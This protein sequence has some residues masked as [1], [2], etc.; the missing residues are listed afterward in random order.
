MKGIF[1][2]DEAIGSLA[3]ARQLHQDYSGKSRSA[4]R[5]IQRVRHAR[6]YNPVGN[7][8]FTNECN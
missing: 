3:V 6:V 4:G 8:E 7:V 1:N 2:N 5:E